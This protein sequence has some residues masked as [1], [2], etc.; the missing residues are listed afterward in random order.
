MSNDLRSDSELL[1]GVSVGTFRWK[2]EKSFLTLPT[3]NST[4]KY[5]LRGWGPYLNSRTGANFVQQVQQDLA[6][7][8]ALSFP[9]S[10]LFALNRL[11][12]TPSTL[13]LRGITDLHIVIAGA[14]AHAEQRLLFDTNYWSEIGQVYKNIAKVHLH[15]VGPEAA[16]L[17]TLER[18]FRT[19]TVGLFFLNRLH[20]LC[21][22]F[23]FSRR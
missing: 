11:T 7:V 12:L 2:R 3:P 13:E 18:K 5:E 6:T 9:L 16:S 14:T 17:S 8:D 23:R 21:T 20:R 10:L 22:R 19:N 4:T 15:F 1:S